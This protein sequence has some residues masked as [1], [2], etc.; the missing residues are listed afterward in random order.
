MRICI[1]HQTAL[2]YLLRMRNPRTH[3]PKPCRARVIPETVPSDADASWLLGVLGHDLPEGH[4]R[5]DVLVS[6]QAGRHATA[7]VRPHLC[8]T[9][10]P[11]GSFLEFVVYGTVVHFSSPE[12][13]FLQMADALE[14]AALV[15]VGYALCSDFRLDDLELSGVT[16]RS[17]GGDEPLTTPE[18]IIAFLKRLPR[19]TRN[20]SKALRAAEHVRAGARS[21]VEAGI[22]LCINLPVSLGGHAFGDVRLNPELRVYDGLDRRGEPCYRTRYPDI[23]VSA[24]DRNG[25][26]R[27]VDVEYSPLLTHGSAERAFGDAERG[28]LLSPVDALSVITLTTVQVQSYRCFTD[29]LDR[30]RRSLKQ[31]QKPRLQSNPDSADN[32][33][34]MAEAAERQHATWQLTLSRERLVL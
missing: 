16:V 6:S 1:S 22:A 27:C 5:L 7:L 17:D 32:Q 8:T 25:I 11:E 34:R 20:R 9:P 2:S 31:R 4:D 29:D 14:P 33:R 19:G 10:L 23:L 13:I 12:L 21:P 28:N 30:I 3:E 18:R 26:E 15:Y 24:H